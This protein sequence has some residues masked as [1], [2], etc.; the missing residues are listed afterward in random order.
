MTT[1]VTAATSAPEV[2]PPAAA[3]AELL[4]IHPKPA[5]AKN[6]DHVLAANPVQRVVA[7][8]LPVRSVE[9]V[10]SG[11]SIEIAI[12]SDAIFPPGAMPEGMSF[13]ANVTLGPDGSA[14]RLGLR[15]RLAGFERRANQ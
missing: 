1:T 10:P 3:G 5:K 11:P 9:S 4:A 7:A 6:P 13:V 12:S 8:P 2:R 14:E 15:P